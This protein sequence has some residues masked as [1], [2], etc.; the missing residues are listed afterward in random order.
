[1]DEQNKTVQPEAAAAPE[2][3][4]LKK[5]APAKDEAPRRRV[6]SFTLGI[7]LIAAGILF[8]C[9]DFVPGF[10]WQ[11][12]LKVAPAAGLVLL[13]GEV[14]WF[15]SHPG[16]WKYDFVSVLVCLLLMG[17]CLCMGF[18]PLIAEQYGPERQQTA[19]RLSQTYTD[20]LYQD[21][22][23]E[24]P[25]V[26]LEDVYTDLYLYTSTVQDLADLEPGDG[27]LRLT[28]TL[29]G[30]YASADDFAKDCRTVADVIQKQA[31]QPNAVTFRCD[32]PLPADSTVRENLDSA[33][34]PQTQDYLL[35]VFGTTQLDWTAEQM[36]RQTEVSGLLDEEN[37][38]SDEAEEAAEP[39]DAEET[40]APSSMDGSGLSGTRSD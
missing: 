33:S 29:F 14:L 18:V 20:T 3:R 19:N 32:A 28:V 30:P 37:T 34:A 12:V 39:D 1:M 38:D 40:E 16:R 9:Y 35:E 10:D 22:K 11:L 8:L 6:G 5:P 4:P 26:Q 31:V 36:A 25:D 7:S 2:S 24:A 27:N 17:V 23:A 21:L 15:A 13:G